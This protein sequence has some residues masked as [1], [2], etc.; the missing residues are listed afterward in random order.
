MVTRVLSSFGRA[1]NKYDRFD[2]SGNG[3]LKYHA[4]E[5]IFLSKQANARSRTERV[6]TV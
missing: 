6:L 3:Q 5:I 2:I 1:L 4:A